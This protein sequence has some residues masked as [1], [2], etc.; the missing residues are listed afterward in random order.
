MPESLVLRGATVVDTRTGE[1][2]P[3]RDVV[4]TGDRI[5]A[6]LP[7]DSSDPT[8]SG[9]RV[10]DVSGTWLVPGFNDIHAH[11][12]EASDPRGTHEL[13]LTFGVTGYRQMSGSA[14]LL[15][16][17]RDGALDFGPNAPALLAA[18]GALLTPL[19]A[20]TPDAIRGTVRGQAEQG[21]D[22]IKMGMVTA[23]VYPA[24]Q[25]EANRIGIP[26]GGHL[27]PLTDALEASAAGI[28]FIEHLGPGI[29]VI[30]HCSTDEERVRTELAAVPQPRIPSI[31]LP[32]MDKLFAVVLKR[33]VV[34]PMMRSNPAMVAVIGR[35]VDTFDDDRA[36]K[37]AAIFA[38]NA[39]WQ[40]PTLIR[41]KTNELGDDPAWAADPDLRFVSEKTL[42]LWR[43][44]GEKF[45]ALP[46]STL[47]V[48]HGLY[49][50]QLRLTKILAEEGVPMIAGSDVT[51]AS[52]EVPGA[53]LHQEF[54]ELARAGLTPLQVL[55][56]TTVEAGRFLGRDDLGV[57]E[58]GSPADLVLLE[59]DP[60]VDVGN[61]HRVT[62]VVRAGRHL[63]R[64]DLDGIQERV[65]DQRSVV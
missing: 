32:F 44:T 13:M 14:D 19:N 35:A 60:T 6:V 42:R 3:D 38:A 23:D 57:V 50:V 10:V 40:S 8:T 11:A 52:W 64:T 12:L 24:G 39:T 2:I 34:S 30:A 29:G 61:L 33:I 25:E 15:R 31:R 41:E 55:Q 53:S 22:F 48:F 21:A 20:G 62:A 36:R 58:A 18:P 16:R 51:G 37:V 45:R 4:L 5:S 59:G 28:R 56:M 26:F 7:A 43:R 17:R 46:E 1:T 27:P 9:A 63:G 65:A 49:D 47:A 54:D